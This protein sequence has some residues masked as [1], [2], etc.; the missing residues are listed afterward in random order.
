MRE[1]FK[2]DLKKLKNSVLD[3][4]DSVIVQFEDTL[5]LMDSFSEEDAERILRG[6]D[7]IDK[8]V[9]DVE[10]AGIQL[11]ATQFPVARD[12]RFIHSMLIINIH[13]ERIGDLIYNTVKALN[14]LNKM[15]Y[16]T[17]EAKESLKKMGL[18]TLKIIKKS[19]NAFDSLD[20]RV[21]EELPVLD[22]EVDEM[23]KNF[24]KDI[25]RISPSL[26]EPEWYLSFAL[27]ARY[28]ERAADQA[29]DVGERVLFM[30]TGK[31]AEID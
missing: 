19:R 26:K 25:Q 31:F 1:Q 16:L 18:S 7:V 29:V 5:K 8:K 28:F 30:I 20:A 2:E 17:D 13:L 22:E 4:F 15:G 9:L 23:F 21:V 12:L 24:L 14:R 27:I 11:V 6:D 10:E 3:V